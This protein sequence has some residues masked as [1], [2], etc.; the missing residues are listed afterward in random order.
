MLLPKRIFL[1]ACVLVNAANSP[2]GG[3]ARLLQLAAERKVKV[4]TTRRILHE[5]KTNIINLLGRPLWAWF[6]RTI[7]PLSIS[8]A[9][10]PTKAEKASWMKVTHEK[11]T[12]VLA[13]AI[14]G[15]AE[16]LISL[17]RRHVLKPSVQEAFPIPIMSPGDFLQKHGFVAPLPPDHQ[18]GKKVRAHSH[19][20]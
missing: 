6:V 8:I 15:K 19:K 14:K 7:G 13:G 11:D 3:S 12:H 16:V 9:D 1:G 2:E 17:D 20:S 4:I 18:S 10:S 5:A